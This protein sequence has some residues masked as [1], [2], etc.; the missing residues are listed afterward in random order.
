MMSY[1]S[2][3]YAPLEKLTVEQNLEMIGR[4]RGLSTSELQKEIEHLLA[5]LEIVEYR[6]KKGKNLSGG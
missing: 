2:Q 3:Q 5:D 6:D 4:M 1:M